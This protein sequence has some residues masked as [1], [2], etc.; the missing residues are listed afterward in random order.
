MGNFMTYIVAHNKKLKLLPEPTETTGAL[1]EMQVTGKDTELG[2]RQDLGN[3]FYSMR[4]DP[5]VA[6]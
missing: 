1:T 3:W 2:D 4:Q 6:H 5:L